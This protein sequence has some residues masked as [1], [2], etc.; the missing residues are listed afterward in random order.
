MNTIMTQKQH[1]RNYS[2]DIA[3][4][5]AI[6]LVV[7]I[8]CSADLISVGEQSE[9]GF[10]IGNIFDALARPGVPLFLMISGALM[11]DE[12]R[13]KSV[14]DCLKAARSILILL[15]L[16]SFIYAVIF[17]LAYPLLQG[18]SVN[19]I[20]F[21]KAVFYGHYHLWYLYMMVG[22]YCA[23]PFLRKIVAKESS[24]LV[25]LF[26]GISL[27]TVFI[28]PIISVVDGYWYGI[29]Y[30]GEFI[31]KLQLDFFGGFITYYL[32]GWYIVHVGIKKKI[33]KNLIYT[34]GG[35]S[36]LLLIVLTQIT[37]D[38]ENVYA[39]LGVFTFLY[40]VS[41]FL[42]INDLYSARVARPSKAVMLFSGLSF[43]IYVIHPMF[44][45][46]LR[47]ILSD[48][49]HPLLGLLIKYVVALLLSL[50]VSYVISKLPILKKLIR[51]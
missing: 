30:L 8:H 29:T 25:L 39:N 24:E 48:A 10:L 46:V 32:V 16:W 31:D 20:D 5:I 22:L 38:Y 11:L 7:M 12:N 42:L 6:L 2:L 18:A 13:T 41:I 33:Y 19:W 28:K 50:G 36:A 47:E 21:L 45:A 14:T 17:N 37:K 23:L 44:V 1:C 43:G 9:L 40:S 3:R 35:L 34:M 15:I 27:C 26:V 51:K 4:M 49:L